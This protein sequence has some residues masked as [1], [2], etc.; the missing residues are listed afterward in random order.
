MMFLLLQTVCVPQLLKAAFRPHAPRRFAAS[1][2]RRCTGAQESCD[3]ESLLFRV[4]HHETADHFFGTAQPS[5]TE[6]RQTAFWQYT[7]V[8]GSA[9][10]LLKTLF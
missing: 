7:R 2:S 6:A 9:S 4:S 10:S 5:I 8:G 1:R 3:T